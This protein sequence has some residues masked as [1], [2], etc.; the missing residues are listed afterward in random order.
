MT[1]FVQA[2]KC[3]HVCSEQ[4]H[5]HNAQNIKTLEK[6]SWQHTNG[7]T[8]LHNYLGATQI[9]DAV[10]L[11]TLATAFITSCFYIFIAL[12]WNTEQIGA[13]LKTQQIT[14]N[15]ILQIGFEVKYYCLTISHSV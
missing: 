13:L 1:T 12:L 14:H 6:L 2:G 5:L 11:H 9:Y 7:T 8:Y 3:E 4:T 15:C 10:C